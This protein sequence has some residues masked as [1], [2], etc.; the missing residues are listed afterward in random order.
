MEIRNPDL[1]HFYFSATLLWTDLLHKT[2]A[3]RRPLA[4]NLFRVSIFSKIVLLKSALAA[5]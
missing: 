5:F 3:D 4:E 1:E 2:L